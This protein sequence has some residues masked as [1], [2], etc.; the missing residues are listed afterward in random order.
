MKRFPAVLRPAVLL[1]IGLSLAALSA[2][3]SPVRVVQSRVASASG[4]SL[5]VTATA[6]PAAG[7]SKVGSTDGIVFMGIIIVLIVILPILFRR[8]SL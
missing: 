8:R 6:T 5:Q 3:L 7:I 4:L 2:T 1:G